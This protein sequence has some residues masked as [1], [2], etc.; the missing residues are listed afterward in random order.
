LPER[1][2]TNTPVYR[3]ATDE[4]VD[5]IWTV[6]QEVAPEIPVLLD[7]PERQEAM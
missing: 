7:T 4:D 1:A 5:G 3:A 2:K 6:L